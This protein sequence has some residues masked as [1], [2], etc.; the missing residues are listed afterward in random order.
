MTKVPEFAG[1]MA[2][3]RVRSR[4]SGLR[5]FGWSLPYP[6]PVGTWGRACP[7]PTR[8][9]EPWTVHF[10][11]IFSL[12]F[13]ALFWTRF[14]SDLGSSWAPFGGL[15]GAQIGS[16]WVKNASWSYLFFENVDVRET[17]R[18]P[19]FLDQNRPQDGPKIASR[20]IQD[21]SKSDK[22]VMHFSSWCL[23]RFGLDLGSFWDPF[24]PP[25]SNQNPQEI[26]EKS[27]SFSI[28][29]SVG[30]KMAP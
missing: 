9:M 17:L 8:A 12:R 15:L 16:S 23:T 7:P 18:S 6:P 20:P 1:P 28:L 19:M 4:A 30:P 29:W 25:K 3:W 21:G 26:W 14:G 5:F 27:V 10:S 24:W 11:I 2:H 22:K 13:W